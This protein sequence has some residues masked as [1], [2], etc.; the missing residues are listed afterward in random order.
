MTFSSIWAAG[1]ASCYCGNSK[2]RR[3]RP[4][5]TQIELIVVR[6]NSEDGL[7]ELSRPTAA[8]DVGNWEDVTEGQIVEVTVTG[9]NKGGLECQIAGLRGSSRWGSYRFTAS[10]IRKNTSA[11]GWPASSPRR[12]GSGET[13]S[14][15]IGP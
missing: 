10:N 9:S 4:K 6:F 5:A 15:A 8:V 13:W 1:K 2:T 11:S 14:S 12:T 7:Y 3:H